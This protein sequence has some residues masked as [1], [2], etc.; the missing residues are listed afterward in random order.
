MLRHALTV[1]VSCAL[2]LSLGALGCKKKPSGP[3]LT[4]GSGNGFGDLFNPGDGS[5]GNT[6]TDWWGDDPFQL[7]DDPNSTDDPG[8]DDAQPDTDG[9]NPTGG[10]GTNPTDVNL[11][12]GGATHG[13]DGVPN[14]P[15]GSTVSASSREELVIVLGPSNFSTFVDHIYPHLNVG[16]TSVSTFTVKNRGASTVSEA[17]IVAVGNVNA[18]NVVTNTCSGQIA[19]TPPASSVSS[20]GPPAPRRIRPAFT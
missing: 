18:F 14:G 11:P 8:A 1:W 10:S 16:Q 2:I 12:D 17:S 5:D 15:G 6:V 20:S 19:P 4:G 9:S 7:V 3:R 13:G